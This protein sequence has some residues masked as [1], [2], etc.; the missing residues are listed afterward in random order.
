M[1]SGGIM[2]HGVTYL[3]R[4]AYRRYK[5]MKLMAPILKTL[6]IW[7]LISIIGSLCIWLFSS[8]V[9]RGLDIEYNMQQATVERFMIATGDNHDS[10]N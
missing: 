4:N 5:L 9:I 10:K 1:D 6:A 7:L 8:L 2:K 3:S